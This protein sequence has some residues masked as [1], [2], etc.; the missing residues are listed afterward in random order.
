MFLA[1]APTLQS[2]RITAAGYLVADV[3]MARTGLYTYGG[4]EVGRSD[5]ETVRVYRPAD[6]VFNSKAMASFATVPVTMGHP[7]AAVSSSTWRDASVGHVGEIV[8]RDGE[9]I[10][11]EIVVMD[12]AAIDQIQSGTAELSCGYQC[13]LDWTAGTTPEGEAYDAVQRRPRGNHLA[14]VPRGRAGSAC[15]IGG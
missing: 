12:Q 1:D 8:F 4:F 13:D 9:F 5:M 10:R 3:R 14:I 6:E 11:G 7:N 15:R 2:T